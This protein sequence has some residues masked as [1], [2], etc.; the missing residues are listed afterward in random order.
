MPGG[1]ACD[2]RYL[3]W[4]AHEIRDDTTDIHG[5]TF[6]EAVCVDGDNFRS[7]D[8]SSKVRRGHVIDYNVNT[9]SNSPSISPRKHSFS[10]NWNGESSDD[11]LLEQPIPRTISWQPTVACLE[12]EFFNV[13]LTKKDRR[14]MN[15]T[16]LNTSRSVQVQTVAFSFFR[17]LVLSHS[18]LLH[19]EKTKTNKSF[20]TQSHLLFDLCSVGFASPEDRRIRQSLQLL[21]RQAHEA[22]GP[23]PQADHHQQATT[24]RTKREGQNP[25]H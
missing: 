11:E 22:G 21:P 19:T 7:F 16:G 14:S 1:V 18:H 10:Y 8:H 6:Y 17:T 13:T 24:V 5:R 9:P 25:R 3:G 12:F 4:I 15:S 23:R 20:F 2:C